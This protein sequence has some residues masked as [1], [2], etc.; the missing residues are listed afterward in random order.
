MGIFDDV[1]GETGF[2]MYRIRHIWRLEDF[3]GLEVLCLS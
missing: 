1:I 3:R 2:E